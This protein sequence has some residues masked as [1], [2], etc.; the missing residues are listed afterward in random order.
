MKRIPL[1]LLLLLL[2][3]CAQLGLGGPERRPERV[4]LWE[5]AHRALAAEDFAQA[6]A[7]F[8]RVAQE[9]PDSDAGRESLFYLGALRLDPRNPS[10]D[11]VPAEE[12]LSH[13]LE[14]DSAY[15][16]SIHRR[17]EA[18]VLLELARQ[19]NMPAEE[20]VPGLQPETRVVTER[21]VVPARESRA[22][23]AEVDRLQRLLAERDATIQQQK[24]ELE[25]IRKTLTGR[26]G[27]E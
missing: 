3:A 12:N 22:L 7:L 6:S 2:S 20:R 26:G 11:P 27:R 21:V 25:R 18:L 23:A 15:L 5:A 1:V 24:E 4:Q 16:A 19:L 14:G 17:P 8:E 13:Y 9:Y 10:W